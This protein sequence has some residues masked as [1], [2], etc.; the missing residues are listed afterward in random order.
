MKDNQTNINGQDV[1]KWK[2]LQTKKRQKPSSL[3]VGVQGSG[4]LL[5]VKVDYSFQLRIGSDQVPID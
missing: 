4:Y 5:F 2:Q 3:G 1:F